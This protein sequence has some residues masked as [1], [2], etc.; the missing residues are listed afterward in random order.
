LYGIIPKLFVSLSRSEG[1]VSASSKRPFAALRM[2]NEPAKTQQNFLYA[3]IVF[4]QRSF[5][6]YL[7][8]KKCNVMLNEVKHPNAL[9]C[10][11]NKRDQQLTRMWDVV[12]RTRATVKG[13]YGDDS[14]EYEF[15]WRYARQRAQAQRAPPGHVSRGA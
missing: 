6:A 3:V 11:R 8:A 14:S 4:C 5:L 7:E 10:L 15:G 12:K 2:T 9:H 1:S 13:T